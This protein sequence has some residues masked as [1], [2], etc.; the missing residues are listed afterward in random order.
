ML[1]V[2]T[3][4]RAP[5]RSF[6]SERL[7]VSRYVDRW[8]WSIPFQ[9][10]PPFRTSLASP[11]CR[12]SCFTLSCELMLAKSDIVVAASDCRFAQLEVKRGI[13]ANHG[14]TI[15]MIERAGWG[16]AMRYLLTGDEFGAA[17][18]YRMRLVQEIVESGR[19]LRTGDRARRTDLCPVAAGHFQPRYAMGRT[20]IRGRSL[21]RRPLSSAQFRQDFLADARTAEGLP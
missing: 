13:M 20:L 17:E 12:A 19:Q 18:A 8:A 6:S 7:H 5:A 15:R 4:E 10:R 3:S 11:Q 16:D 9:L 1:L 21:F 2:R 14:A